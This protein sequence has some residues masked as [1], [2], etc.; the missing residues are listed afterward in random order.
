MYSRL[1]LQQQ[2]QIKNLFWNY[3]PKKTWIFSEIPVRQLT[4]AKKVYGPLNLD[5]GEVILL[6][7]TTTFGSGKS[8]YVLTSEAFY[9]NL[10]NDRP[11]VFK[12]A[13]I[14]HISHIEAK[15]QHF[16]KKLA[17]SFA[18]SLVDSLVGGVVSDIVCDVVDDFADDLGDDEKIVLQLHSGQIYGT[19]LEDH[20]EDALKLLVSTWQVL[21]PKNY[22]DALN[23][24]VT[25][26]WVCEGC[27]A[28]NEMAFC[29]YC[30]HAK[31]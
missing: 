2:E 27:G 13:N 15:N 18:G 20:D 21:S 26:S 14:K 4:S 8:G 22:S 19:E 1:P 16:L 5:H 17:G 10:F 6:H 29:S 11:Q 31:T 30:G 3:A 28:S 7:D 23:E 25:T 12:L 24:N 9:T